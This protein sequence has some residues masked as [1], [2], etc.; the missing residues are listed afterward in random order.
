MNTTCSAIAVVSTVHARRASEPVATHKVLFAGHNSSVYSRK[1]GPLASSVDSADPTADIRAPSELLVVDGTNVCFWY[2]QAFKDR[3]TGADRVSIRLLLVLL[4]EIRAHGDDFYC[5]FD[6]STARH[7]AQRG[8][9]EDARL[10]D[11]LVRRYPRH[12]FR[13]T[14]DSSADAAIVHFANRQN[15]RIV[16]NDTRYG[17]RFGGQCPWL[18]TPHSPRLIRGNYQRTG[19]M[20]LER[21]DYGFIEVSW[22]TRTGEMLQRLSAELAA[23]RVPRPITTEV[24]VIAANPV[25]NVICPPD[26]ELPEGVMAPKAARVRTGGSR[27]LSKGDPKPHKATRSSPKAR[28]TAAGRRARPARS[29][30]TR[31]TGKAGRGAPPRTSGWLSQLLG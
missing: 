5:I 26:H 15:Y 24:Q 22:E 1:H 6:A 2:G 8:K 30:K 23:P 19:L 29:R 25:A 11:E 14:G 31:A 18:R 27:T 3:R 10:I 17:E 21:L 20:T 16:T 4:A 28:K 13:V 7:I 9:V 12:F